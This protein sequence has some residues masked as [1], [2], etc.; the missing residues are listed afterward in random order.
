MQI[1]EDLIKLICKKVGGMKNEKKNYFYSLLV[2][3]SQ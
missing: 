2:L 1:I 3:S